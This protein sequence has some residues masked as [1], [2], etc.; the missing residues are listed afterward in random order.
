MKKKIIELDDSVSVESL[1]WQKFK[2]YG[3][4]GVMVS[5]GDADYYGRITMNDFAKSCIKAA[6]EIGL[7][8]DVNAA[9]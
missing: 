8:E 3:I 4:D 2:K 1:D 5:F 6:D 7:E 9:K